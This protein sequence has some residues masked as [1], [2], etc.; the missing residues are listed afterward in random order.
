M[1]ASDCRL[2]QD[3]SR[4][5]ALSLGDFFGQKLVVI[6]CPDDE[7]AASAEIEAYQARAAA[8]QSVGAWL[9]AVTRG[10]DEPSPDSNNAHVRSTVD[11][12]GLAFQMLAARFPEVTEAKD[13]IVFLIDRDGIARHAWQGSGRADDVLAGVRER[14]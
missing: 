4:S 5:G 3:N 9:V 11:P 6:F 10:G 1:T 8:F 14:P 2:Q 13:G 7:R 12:D